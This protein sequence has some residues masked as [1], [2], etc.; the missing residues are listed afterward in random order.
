[1]HD[2]VVVGAGLA[3]LTSARILSR[4]GRRVRVLEASGAVGGRVRSRVL[5]GFT[6][7]AGYQVLFPSYPAVK[8][9]LDLN[10]LD[11]VAIAPSAAV[12]RGEREDVLGDPRRDLAA[13][14][15]T[16]T[17]GVLGVDDKLRVGKLALEVL[18]LPPHTLLAG[19]D[20]TTESYLR[21]QGFSE[22][23]LTNFFRPFF[24]GIFLRRDLDTSARLFRY[25]FRML[26]DGGAALPRAG[27]GAIPA[28]LAA[29]LDIQVGVR[30]TGLRAHGS[31]VTLQTSNGEL[32][33]RS[34]IVATDPNTAAALLGQD[35]S[36]GS[37]G[38]TYLYYA[39]ERRVDD[40]P[41]LLLNAETGLINNAQWLSNVLP[42]RVPPGQHLLTV[43]VL[44][45]PP[46]D[47]A[48][49]DASVR[50]ELETWYGGAA[51]AGLRTLA[52]ERI[53]H[54]QYPQPPGYAATLPGHATNLPGVLL[55]SEATSMSGIQ[56]AMESGEKAAAILLEDLTALSRP[57]GG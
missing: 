3:G 28:Q 55:A 54:A 5:D 51:V 12:R 34:V 35:V 11:L 30:V 20:E 32:D 31:H 22:A 56:G 43:T 19:P 44:G 10:A 4:A 23:A 36:R 45:L 15:S 27:M 42:G 16:L 8:R 17:T 26:I 40:Q 50:R 52:V 47:D 24:G 14:P 25:Y 38:S 37:L 49:L 53:P 29:G 6:L 21:G 57:R 39:S 46:E 7:D 18:T 13:L 48:G 33:A 1:M 9:H 41:R 2:T